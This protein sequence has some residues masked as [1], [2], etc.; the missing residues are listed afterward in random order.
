M[1]KVRGFI[2]L[3]IH[4]PLDGRGELEIDCCRASRNKGT[5]TREVGW[6]EP[7]AWAPRSERHLRRIKRE[8]SVVP[9]LQNATKRIAGRANKSSRFVLGTGRESWD[10][11]SIDKRLTWQ[12]VASAL[13]TMKIKGKGFAL[14]SGNRRTEKETGAGRSGTI[15]KKCAQNT[16]SREWIISWSYF[17]QQTP[18]GSGYFAAWAHW[19]SMQAGKEGHLLV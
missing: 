12:G 18:L 10:D 14:Q 2:P 11:A 17:P 19:V 9:R 7:W 3:Q 1:D 16:L 15:S 6:E 4:G 5:Q 13:T 8:T